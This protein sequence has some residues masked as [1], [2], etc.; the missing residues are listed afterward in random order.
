MLPPGWPPSWS[1]T[2]SIWRNVV[3]RP[4]DR[5]DLVDEPLPGQ[6]RVRDRG[7]RR[8]VVVLDLL[9][10]D[11]VRAAH[12]L[13]EDPRQ[14]LRTC[15]SSAST[16]VRFSTFIEPTDSSSRRGACVTSR[17][18]PL[19]IRAGAAVSRYLKLPNE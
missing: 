17:R 19:S 6:R 11:D 14:P 2:G 10:G 13:D 18:R 3:G 7:V 8:A 4:A 5:R 12:V 16:N 15:A 1:S 9:D